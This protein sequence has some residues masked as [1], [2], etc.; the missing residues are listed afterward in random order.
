V[1]CRKDFWGV[2]FVALHQSCLAS[3]DVMRPQLHALP[4]PDAKPTSQGE[5]H[6]ARLLFQ[7]GQQDR[8]AF[9]TLYNLWAPTLLGIAMR[10]L[11]QRQEAEEVVQ[12]AFVKIWH[13]AASY[14][15]ERSQAFVWCFAIMR[16]L[17]IDRIRHHSRQ[18]RDR[19]MQ[20]S[21]ETSPAADLPCDPLILSQD[22]FIAVRNAMKQLPPDERRCL[23]LAVF[24][25]YTHSEISGHLQ[26]PLGTVKNRLRRALEK[27]KHFLSDHEL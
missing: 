17:C 9:D 10:M 12:D 27:L 16:S 18:K 4:E 19:S 24:L 26:T 1:L 6:V 23:E 13:R 2:I 22:T 5:D 8:F 20:C 14:D 21:F 25:E 7:V 11:G 3:F 15:P